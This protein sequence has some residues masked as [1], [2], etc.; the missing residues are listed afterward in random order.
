MPATPVDLVT[1]IS[2][3]FKEI[4][5]LLREIVSTKETRRLRYRVE[6]AMQYIFVD[7]KSGEYAKI[8]DKAR[9]KLKVHFR[10][11]VFDSN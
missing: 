6:S 10:R 3:A 4:A 5:G 1:A 9:E 8:T 2:G 7:E 11:R